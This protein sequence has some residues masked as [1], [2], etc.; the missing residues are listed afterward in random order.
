MV[1]P[2]SAAQLVSSDTF[3]YYHTINTRIYVLNYQK[4]RNKVK[5]K[6]IAQVL[7]DKNNEKSKTSK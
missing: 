7:E 3:I 6:I 5:Y 4:E 2:G 1:Q